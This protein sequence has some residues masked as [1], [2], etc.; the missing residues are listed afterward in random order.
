MRGLQERHRRWLAWSLLLG[1]LLLTAARPWLLRPVEPKAISWN[2][3]V[4]LVDGHDL[5]GVTVLGDRVVGAMRE[6]WSAARPP[7][8]VAAPWPPDA[9]RAAFASG[10]RAQGLTVRDHAER[11]SRALGPLAWIGL[12]ILFALFYWV[13]GTAPRSARLPIAAVPRRVAGSGGEV[14]GRVHQREMR[15]G[16]REITQ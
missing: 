9:D 14:V 4:T 1:M 12:V 6:E 3:L 5:I 16:L 11:P 8:Q 13:A 2:Q 15:K 7:V 10:A